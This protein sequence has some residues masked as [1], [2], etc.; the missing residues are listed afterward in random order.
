MEGGR[1]TGGRRHQPGGGSTIRNALHAGRQRRRRAA[2][3][4]AKENLRL[5]RRYSAV[6]L[7]TRIKIRKIRNRMS[8]GFGRTIGQRRI[9]IRQSDDAST[10]RNGSSRLITLIAE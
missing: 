1:R 9:R 8:E 10:S 5:V 6:T 7:L 4:P 2:R 3:R